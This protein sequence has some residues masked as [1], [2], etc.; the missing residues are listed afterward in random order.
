MKQ[1]KTISELLKIYLKTFVEAERILAV[2]RCQA[3]NWNRVFNNFLHSFPEEIKNSNKDTE[4]Y[5]F[6]MTL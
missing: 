1:Q 5:D 4:L 6:F 2:D 3:M